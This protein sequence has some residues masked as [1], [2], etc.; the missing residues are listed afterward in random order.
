MSKERIVTYEFDPDNPPHLTQKQK[1][2]LEALSDMDDSDI[3]YT[4]LPDQ[5]QRIEKEFGHRPNT[6]LTTVCI[7]TDIL[8]WLRT[9]GRDFQIKLNDILR[10]EMLS[11]QT[12]AISTKQKTKSESKKT[13]TR[14]KR[15]QTVS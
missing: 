6:R 8:R 10:K 9:F 4:D 11:A 12:D 3:D 2:S 15:R 1:E 5:S 13:K 7:D 14:E